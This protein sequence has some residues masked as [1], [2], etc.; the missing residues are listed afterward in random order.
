MAEQTWP[1]S[2]EAL[3]DLVLVRGW[4]YKEV[5]AFFGVSRDAVSGRCTRLGVRSGRGT[6]GRDRKTRP[7]PHRA[8]PRGAASKA[9]RPGEYNPQGCKWIDGDT[10][11]PGYKWCGKP[12]ADTIHSYCEEHL[13]RAYKVLRT[14]P[15][16][17]SIDSLNSEAG[18][19]EKF[20]TPDF[21]PGF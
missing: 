21:S 2:A 5:A 16:K 20:R 18:A 10:W 7:S 1:L 4:T 11:K 6:G 9:K 19:F 8:A 14:D 17:E 12:L 3:R 13:R 15:R